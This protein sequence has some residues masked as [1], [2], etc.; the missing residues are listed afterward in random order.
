MNSKIR[1]L[2]EQIRKEQNKIDRC[3]HQF[4]EPFYNAE[5]VKEPY[6]YEMVVQ[7]SDTWYNPQGY[8]DV[9]KDRWT[10]IC[11]FCE[12]EQ[13]TKDQVATAHKPLFK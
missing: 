9:K 10:R 13:H 3:S 12:Y 5:I 6:G 7:G 2:Q 1:E 8:R 4:D 11:K